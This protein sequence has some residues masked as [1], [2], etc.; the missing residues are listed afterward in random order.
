MRVW[1]GGSSMELFRKLFRAIDDGSLFR[2]ALTVLFV[3]CALGWIAQALILGALLIRGMKYAQGATVFGLLLL[4]ITVIAS[5]AGA[6]MVLF[7]RGVSRMGEVRG[8][9]MI[10]PLLARFI[11][12][13]SEAWF[14]ALIVIAAGGTLAVLFGGSEI[15]QSI[16]LFGVRYLQSIE[17]HLLGSIALFILA[18]I[19]AI[20]QLI[21]FYAVAELLETL[22][23]IANDVNAIRA[24]KEAVV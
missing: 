24:K 13:I 6:V 17:N 19:V 18:L 23:G 21:V 2:S 11:R 10:V 9:N 3:L 7:V 15:S 12:V 8:P 14:V 1:K 22:A 20:A 5:G 4:A 16:P